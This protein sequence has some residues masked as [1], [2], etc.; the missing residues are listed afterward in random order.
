MEYKKKEKSSTGVKNIFRNFRSLYT[1]LKTWRELKL[2][3]V[4]WLIL[5]FVITFKVF[6]S[7]ILNFILVKKTIDIET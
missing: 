4:G 7:N 5:R 3:S 6:V 2:K 1:I